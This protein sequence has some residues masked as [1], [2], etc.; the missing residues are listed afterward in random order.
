MTNLPFEEWK[1]VLGSERRQP[2]D[3]AGAGG[4]REG[5]PIHG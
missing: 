5:S 4:K 1:E 2:A 3:P